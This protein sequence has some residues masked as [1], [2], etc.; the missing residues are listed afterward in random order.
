MSVFRSGFHKKLITS[1]TSAHNFFAY[2][3]SKN[4]ISVSPVDFSER[5]VENKKKIFVSNLFLSKFWAKIGLWLFEIYTPLCPKWPKQ[6]PATREPA[7]KP[8]VVD[9]CFWETAIFEEKVVMKM[10]A[11]FREFRIDFFRP[12]TSN[13]KKMR[14]APF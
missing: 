11:N 8:K 2:D 6:K 9:K 1:W 5:K 10:Y 13:W 12:A 14:L 3:N 4:H 7:V